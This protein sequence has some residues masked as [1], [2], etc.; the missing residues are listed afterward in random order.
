MSQGIK[1]DA[2][3]SH[4]QYGFSVQEDLSVVIQQ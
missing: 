2:I 1:F 3:K 4:V